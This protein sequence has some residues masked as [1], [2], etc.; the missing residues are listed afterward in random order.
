MTKTMSAVA[1]GPARSDADRL[2]P[3]AAPDNGGPHA[4]NGD[5]APTTVNRAEETI[6]D[7]SDPRQQDD[8]EHI[9]TFRTARSARSAT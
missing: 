7:R 6:Q 3:D 2:C 4:D 1:C 9:A 8:R 5:H